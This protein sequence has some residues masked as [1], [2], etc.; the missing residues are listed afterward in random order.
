M[1]MFWP[2]EADKSEGVAKGDDENSNNGI[3]L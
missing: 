1:I 2:W 3:I